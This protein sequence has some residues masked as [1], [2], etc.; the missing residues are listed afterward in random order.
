MSCKKIIAELA[1]CAVLSIFRTVLEPC[2]SIMSNKSFFTSN[3]CYVSF[4]SSK[5]SGLSFIPLSKKS[6][7]QPRQQ[8]MSDSPARALEGFLSFPESDFKISGNPQAHTATL[9]DDL[10][11]VT[12][13]TATSIYSCGFVQQLCYAIHRL[14]HHDKLRFM[15]F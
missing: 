7:G 3:Q 1:F 11:K 13:W 9:T 8:S 10:H 15:L 2:I 12:I 6:R 14:I 5:F 4:M